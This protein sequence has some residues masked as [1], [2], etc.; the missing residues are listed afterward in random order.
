MESNNGRAFGVTR[1]GEIVWQW[2]DPKIRDG[3]RK[4]VYRMIRVY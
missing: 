4:T 3:K 2:Y 1:D